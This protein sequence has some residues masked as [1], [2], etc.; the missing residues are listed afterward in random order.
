MPPWSL[1][2]FALNS[3]EFI[4]ACRKRLLD[5]A[6]DHRRFELDELGLA[7]ASN[8]LNLAAGII[9][10]QHAKGHNWQQSKA[11]TTNTTGHGRRA[12]KRD[13]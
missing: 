2:E 13:R 7:T 11:L 4:T 9:P 6:I 5:A 10:A 1:P 8:D 12:T 3:P